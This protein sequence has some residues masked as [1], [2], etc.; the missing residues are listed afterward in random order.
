MCPRI[1][2]RA[3]DVMHGCHWFLIALPKPVGA[4]GF[5]ARGQNRHFFSVVG[6]RRSTGMS[7]DISSGDSCKGLLY[8]TFIKT[9]PIHVD[10]ARRYVLRGF[11]GIVCPTV[12][13][14]SQHISEAGA[15][16]DVSHTFVENIA[17]VLFA[18]MIVGFPVQVVPFF[19]WD[20]HNY[21][22]GRSRN[23]P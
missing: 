20:V 2:C 19:C 12:P 11:G 6:W 4:K 7:G 13:V 3:S 9:P 8:F 14:P 18:S 5:L 22:F 17:V 1:L 23:G 15:G 10:K 21:W 16:A